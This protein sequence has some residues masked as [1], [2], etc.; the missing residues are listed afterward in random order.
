M[1]LPL[2]N[3]DGHDPSFTPT[4]AFVECGE[5]NCRP[6]LFPSQASRGGIPEE[7]ALPCHTRCWAEMPLPLVLCSV[8]HFLLFLAL[9]DIT[10]SFSFALPIQFNKC[11]PSLFIF[12]LAQGSAH[13]VSL[14][15]TQPQHCLNKQISFY[16]NTRLGSPSDLAGFGFEFSCESQGA[17]L[18]SYRQGHFHSQQPQWECVT[19]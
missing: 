19:S 14:C 8:E 9:S 18:G 4:S 16:F 10:H 17:R 11:L 2:D 15:I 5:G 1:E 7:L 6:F 13:S 3:R 12:P